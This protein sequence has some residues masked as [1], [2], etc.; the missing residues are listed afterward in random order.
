MKQEMIHT[1]KE[2]TVRE[3]KR[4][5]MYGDEVKE[6]KNIRSGKRKR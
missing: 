3:N 1:E 6:K 5:K 2:K 4:V